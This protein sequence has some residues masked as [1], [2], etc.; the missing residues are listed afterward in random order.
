MASSPKIAG[1]VV[2]PPATY[3]ASNVVVDPEAYEKEMNRLFEVLVHS[4]L[5]KPQVFQLLLNEE[6]TARVTPAA[7]STWSERLSTVF[8]ETLTE[9][10]SI[11]SALTSHYVVLF[12]YTHN[13]YDKYTMANAGLQIASAFTFFNKKA[14]VTVDLMKSVIMQALGRGK[15]LSDL[16]K[17]ITEANE[18]DRKRVEGAEAEIG[19]AAPD[20]YAPAAAAPVAA[21]P[22]APMVAPQALTT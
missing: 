19:P 1:D 15:L 10:Q 16:L 20:G 6:K 13:I 12:C 5:L 4:N 21:A 3:D 11:S 7:F 18:E 17:A 2:L 9:L 14:D 8:K 22:Q